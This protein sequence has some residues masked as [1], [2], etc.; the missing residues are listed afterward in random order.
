MK[1]ASS[2][3]TKQFLTSHQLTPKRLGRTDLY[4]A[5]AGF[6]TYRID[7]VNQD[8]RSSL[9]HAIGKGINVI[10]T[11]ANYTDGKSESCVGHILHELYDEGVVQRDQVVVMTKAGY[12]QGETYKENHDYPDIVTYQTGLHHCIHPDFLAAELEKSL[13]RLQIPCIDVFLLH[14]PEYYKL[15]AQQDGTDLTVANKEYYDRIKKAFE[16]LETA[17]EEGLIRH[18]GISSNTFGV[19]ESVYSKTCIQTT[20]AIAES[21]SP[22][23]HFS[24]V[25]FPLNLLETAPAVVPVPDTNQ[26]TCQFAA[27]HDLGV[28]INRPLNA[29]S[30]QQMCRLVELEIEEDVSVIEVDDMLLE[31]S[32]T[33]EQL[34][35]TVQ[36]F[37][38]SV[39]SSETVP[40]FDC[41]ALLKQ[42]W[43]SQPDVFSWKN[44][45]DTFLVPRIEHQCGLIN[46]PDDH[47]KLFVAMDTYLHGMKETSRFMN[48][49]FVQRHNHKI[50]Q[51]TDYLANKLPDWNTT[52]SITNK[53]LRALR[54]TPGVTS[55]LVGMRRKSY[56]D[57][58]VSDLTTPVSPL[59][60]E[61]WAIMS[62][63]TF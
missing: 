18:Y 20:L 25:Q 15:K 56:V 21:L 51:L 5:E 41:A 49:Y 62:E 1:Y 6:G 8:H 48:S 44:V 33:E 12:I 22:H 26:T 36:E 23:H 11:S 38:D 53:A 31:F 50:Y 43:M 55:V 46:F 59:P 29:L 14:N 27:A 61:H 57:T 30:G 63:F 4:V 24:V 42:I 13:D 28:F 45:L 47:E 2:E 34:K 54:Q 17:V 7:E 52:F 58:I 3:Q 19:A 40:D 60:D 37:L 35:Q 39:D 16:F 32:L 9:K 10:D